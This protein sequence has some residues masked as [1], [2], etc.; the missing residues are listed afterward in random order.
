M[1]PPSPHFKSDT[2]S[3]CKTQYIKMEYTEKLEAETRIHLHSSAQ[4]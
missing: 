3:L 1:T 2:G 4:R